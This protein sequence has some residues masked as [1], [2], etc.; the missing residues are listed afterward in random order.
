MYCRKYAADAAW[1]RLVGDG[2]VGKG[3]MRFFQEV[4]ALVIFELDVL[5]ERGRTAIEWRI[6]EWCDDRPDLRKTLTREL[7]HGL[8]M[9]VAKHRSIRV[10]IELAIPWSPPQQ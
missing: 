7:A 6:N 3:K 10:V 5:H 1:H 4:R 2:T 9:L 8:R